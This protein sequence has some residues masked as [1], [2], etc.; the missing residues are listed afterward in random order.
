MPP[1]VT[2]TV[3]ARIVERKPPSVYVSLG[4]KAGKKRLHL[5]TSLHVPRGLRVPIRDWNTL[6]LHSSQTAK[7][8]TGTQIT[9]RYGH[10]NEHDIYAR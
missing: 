8:R 10:E 3:L 7:S 4:Q 1:Q 5:A 9:R 2:S 6:R